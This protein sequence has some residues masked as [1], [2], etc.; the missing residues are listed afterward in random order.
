MGNVP[1]GKDLSAKKKKSEEVEL[2]ALQV[3]NS[4]KLP[5]YYSIHSI[6]VNVN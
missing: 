2:R 4:Q 3:K 6:Y 1:A 5:C